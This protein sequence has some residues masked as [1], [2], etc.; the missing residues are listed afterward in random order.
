MKIKLLTIG[1]LLYL[2]GNLNAQTIYFKPH[3]R[4]HTP[5]TT[6]EAPEYFSGIQPFPRPIFFKSNIQEFSLA[7]GFSYGGAIGVK[8]NKAFG[9]ELGLDYFHND[10]T[11][12]P[13]DTYSYPSKWNFQTFNITPTVT[14]NQPIK[15]SKSRA[16]IKGGIIL[17][18]STLEKT[19][20][21][22]ENQ[23]TYNFSPELSLGYLIGAEYN[24]S[25][26]QKFSIN[27]EIGIQNQ[28][29]TPKEGNAININD[30]N[31]YYLPRTNRDYNN[32]KDN[33]PVYRTKIEYV[34]EI[35]DRDDIIPNK[36]TSYGYGF[37][38]PTTTYQPNQYYYANSNII[39]QDR[40]SIRLRETLNLNSV[41]FS[42]GLTY[43]IRT[44][45]NN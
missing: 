25:I 43:N 44:N 2:L 13:D 12:E 15:S 4:Y 29:Y 1:L 36:Y 6:Q 7:K 37:N 18:I 30:E 45:E 42:I 40:P 17:G 5:L 9:F 20:L 14:F 35:R 3:L 10:D 16:S 34:K 32:D 11:F 19:L 33:L 28:F 27:A 8:T 24:Y 21:I 38:I 31:A 26:N 22:R 39:S 41:Y 23:L